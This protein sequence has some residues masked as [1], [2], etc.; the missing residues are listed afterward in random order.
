M[1]IRTMDDRDIT[2][3]IHIAATAERLWDALTG[4]EALKQCW[5]IIHSD[6]SPGAKVAEVSETGK[7]LW[8][9]EVRRCEPPRLLS[10]TFDVAGIDEKPTEVS[11]E[12]SPPVSPIK[13]GVFVTRLTVVQSGF[14]K[15]SKLRADCARAWTEI[16]SS[17]KSYVETGRALPFDW[18]H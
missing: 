1:E 16:L 17:I 2:Y 15:D 10:F 11:F 6:W 7:V 14:A 18:K 8:Q 13:T 9:G 12:A 4:P 3:V 5:G